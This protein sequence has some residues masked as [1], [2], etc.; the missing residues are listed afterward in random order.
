MIVDTLPR[1]VISRRFAVEHDRPTKDTCPKLPGIFHW[2]SLAVYDT[3]SREHTNSTD[4]L[5]IVASIGD[6]TQQPYVCDAIREFAA[7]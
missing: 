2:A 3:A 1:I 5:C 6:E 4:T 7:R